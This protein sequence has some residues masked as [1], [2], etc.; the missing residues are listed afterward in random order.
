[1]EA[2]KQG[3]SSNIGLELPGDERILLSYY[4]SPYISSNFVS[5]SI[6]WV[7]TLPI[8]GWLAD[9]YLKPYKMTHWNIF[10]MW[11]ISQKRW[12]MSRHF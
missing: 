10:I 6:T 7:L 4:L 11:I 8:A 3:S 2:Q 5:H 12:K 1:M 9:V